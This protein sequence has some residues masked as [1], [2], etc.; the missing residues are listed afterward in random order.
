MK[1]FGLPHYSVNTINLGLFVT[2]RVFYHKGL[3][4]AVDLTISYNSLANASG[5]FGCKW[6]FAYES[7]IVQGENKLN[8][9]SAS[10]KVTSFNRVS[11]DENTTGWQTPEG[12]FDT[13]EEHDGF[14]R[15]FRKADR[16]CFFYHKSSGEDVCRLSAIADHNQNTV[17]LEYQ[18]DG[19]IYKIIDAVGR[20]IIFDYHEGGWCRSFSLQ[21]G[22]TATFEY[23]L[24]GNLIKTIDFAG[25]VSAYQYDN[26]G[27][28]RTMSVGKK[29]RTTQ[30]SYV[31][32]GKFKTLETITDTKG[33]QTTYEVTSLE[34]RIIKVT[35]PEGNTTLYQSNNGLTE[36]ITD[37]LGNYSSTQYDD[38][39]PILFCDKRGNE[40]SYAYDRRGNLVKIF[41]PDNRLYQLDYDNE[42][43]LVRVTDPLAYQTVF[44]YDNTGNLTNTLTPS[45]IE[46]TYCYDRKGQ[47]IKILKTGDYKISLAHDS[48]GNLVSVENSD[49]ITEKL[50]YDS[51]GYR[52]I[53]TTDDHGNTYRYDYDANNRVTITTNPDGSS[54]KR[55][56]DC[57]SGIQTI[58]EIGNRI[59]Y[60]RDSLSN[61][62]GLIDA[63]GVKTTYYY[64]DNNWL[65]KIVDPINRVI[66]FSPNAIGLIKSVED[67]SGHKVS[68]D[69]DEEGNLISFIDAHGKFIN[70]SYNENNEVVT[71]TNF[72]GESVHFQRDQLGR[73]QSVENA[74]G[75]HVSLKY[76]SEDRII[77]KK[78]DQKIIAT[79]KID[80]LNNTVMIKNGRGT[81]RMRFNKSYQPVEIVYPNNLKA[82]FSYDRT[83]NLEQ[84]EYGDFLKVNYIYDQRDRISSIQWNKQAI[85]FAYDDADNLLNET[86]SNGTHTDYRVNAKHM[87]LGL[88]HRKGGDL[89]AGI[90][91]ERDAVDRII[92]ADI[93]SPL[94]PSKDFQPYQRSIKLDYANKAVIVNGERFAFDLDGNLTSG[95]DWAAVFDAENRLVEITRNGQTKH[96]NY[97]MHGHR[98]SEKCEGK[99]VDFHYDL[100]GR[101]L[102]ES[103]EKG[104]IL[105]ACVYYGRRLIARVTGQDEVFFYH[106]DIMGNTTAITDAEGNLVS[107]YDYEPYGQIRASEGETENNRF[108]FGGAYGVMDEG[109]GLY[110]YKR[111]FYHSGFG[112]FIQ[113]DP[114]GLSGGGN[115]YA[116]AAGNPMLYIDPEGTAVVATTLIILTGLGA[117]VGG[118]TVYYHARKSQ[119]EL[120]ALAAA[121]RRKEYFVKHYARATAKYGDAYVNNEIAKANSVL[122]QHMV[123]AKDAAKDAVVTAA[124]TTVETVS[125]PVGIGY[126]ITKGAINR[127]SA[128]AEERSPNQSG[129]SRKHS[130]KDPCR[131]PSAGTN[132][133]QNQLPKVDLPDELDWDSLDDRY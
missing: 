54:I 41:Y 49:G 85:S 127:G 90:D 36:R 38:G 83:A 46:I 10:G 5:M 100:A 130:S 63:I 47:L 52:L 34:P 8:I 9:I 121:R 118:G 21:D 25:I 40:T 78:Y 33:H 60:E 50:I 116:F 131:P 37:A 99:K 43:R 44:V 27:Y 4:P 65:T 119:A 120:N 23:D 35:F 84:I 56:Y 82:V 79:R 86:R 81:T 133:R 93:H 96:Y 64:N 76:D 61:I 68:F 29:K 7:L 71:I 13:L 18:S 6:I 129:T 125:T 19:K 59:T 114:I 123:G 73:I 72:M 15:Y 24:N 20:E 106:Y 98:V 124:E 31:D 94:M 1:L 39:K 22:R 88:S 115:D 51:Y 16:L 30:F 74:R 62:V 89:F 14:W 101:L 97:D 42:N 91:L 132:K 87:I 12:C 55:I 95:R 112:M 57:C 3:G 109:Q 107:A 45:G 105:S 58:D 77:E 11:V 17:R 75:N 26:E 32:H 69:Y 103:N 110:A 128:K 28:L 53:E 108:T 92:K 126:N 102:F 2:D 113:S 122:Y 66:S 48:L 80:D 104:E 117:L 67:P 70:Y 111:R